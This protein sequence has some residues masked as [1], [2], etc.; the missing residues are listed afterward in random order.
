MHLHM[1]SHMHLLLHLLLHMHIHLLPLLFLTSTLA[2]ALAHP[3]PLRRRLISIAA[4]RA[5]AG[6][7]SQPRVREE[8]AATLLRAAQQC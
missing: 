8:C 5:T 6:G 7:R 2:L 4:P 1:Y 3:R